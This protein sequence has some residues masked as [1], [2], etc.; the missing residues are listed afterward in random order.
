MDLSDT[1]DDC[2][3]H[4][5]LAGL[6]SRCPMITVANHPDMTLGQLTS[7]CADFLS[8][9][10]WEDEGGEIAAFM[11][12]DAA[13]IAARFPVGTKLRASFDHTLDDWRF[14]KQQEWN[15]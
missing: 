5:G 8:G 13:Q 4:H 15:R 2:A 3:C 11:A 6:D 10:G 14:T 12:A 1:H 7:A 9:A